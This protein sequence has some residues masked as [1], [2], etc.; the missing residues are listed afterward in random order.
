MHTRLVQLTIRPEHIDD[1]LEA[2]H[3]NIE[4]SMQDEP[5]VV[6]FYLLQHEDIRRFTLIEVYAND[7]ARGEHLMSEHYLTWRDAVFPMFE[8]Q[9]ESIRVMPI[10][11]PGDEWDS[12]AEA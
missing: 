8:Q 10:I 7:E 2:T 9:M 11:V 4:T 6:R 12:L 5:G 3:K 1:F